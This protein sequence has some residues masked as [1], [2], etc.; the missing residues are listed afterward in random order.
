[1]ETDSSDELKTFYLNE[2][3]LFYN[4]MERYD[5]YVKYVE[6]LRQIHKSSGNLVCA[7]HTLKL[8][9]QLLNWT[10]ERVESYLEHPCSS[11]TSHK[12]LKEV[13]FIDIINDFT[14]G[15]AWEK[16]LEFSKILRER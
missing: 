5:I 11:L 16:A 13:M 14:E 4:T 10:N 3:L 1:M 8:H 15:Q 2:I 9:A 6:I 12:G 7:A